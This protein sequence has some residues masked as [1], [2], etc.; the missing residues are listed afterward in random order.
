[1]VRRLQG[2][3]MLVNLINLAYSAVK[4]LPYVDANFS[5]YQ[6]QSTQEFRFLLSEQIR[7]QIIFTNF[8]Q[9][10][11]NGIKTKAILTLF[12]Q[13]VFGFHSHTQNL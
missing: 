6:T 10:L 2:M 5:S 1:M 13:K 11:E 3:E 12:K 9:S 8:T 7:E 4:L